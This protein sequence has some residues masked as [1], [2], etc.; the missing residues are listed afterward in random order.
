MLNELGTAKALLTKIAGSYS[1]AASE[2]LKVLLSD[3]SAIRV[4]IS[5]EI[6]SALG[7]TLQMTP[8]QFQQLLKSPNSVART[9][10]NAQAAAKVAAVINEQLYVEQSL[11]MQRLEEIRELIRRIE[12][13]ETEP[14]SNLDVVARD[15]AA[16]K[17]LLEDAK[18]TWSELAKKYDT[19][20]VNITEL[21]KQL[22]ITHAQLDLVLTQIT[23]HVKV[24]Q[25]EML[26]VLKQLPPVEGLT[27]V[28]M[29]S[30]AD[31]YAERMQMTDPTSSAKAHAMYQQSLIALA[32][33]ADVDSPIDAPEKTNQKQE[34]QQLQQTQQALTKLSVMDA[35][36]M[37][38]QDIAPA[39]RNTKGMQLEPTAKE[40][41]QAVKVINTMQKTE[42]PAPKLGEP[43][44]MQNV[45]ERQRE[46]LTPQF[47]QLDH[48]S[49]QFGR[50]SQAMQSERGKILDMQNASSVLT[51]A[52]KP[53]AMTP[54]MSMGPS[55]K[56]DPEED[57]TKTP[58]YKSPTPFNMRLTPLKGKLP[59]AR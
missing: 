34:Q 3:L 16:E 21:Q 50:L 39:L 13:R 2:S 4:K 58:D 12:A 23:K 8:A 41:L 57:Q 31:N 20:V 30:I 15:L 59:P 44:T 6:M 45:F 32:K 27:A 46:M 28:H 17:K 18:K 29:A 5:P 24:Y 42:V 49:R 22:D 37:I 51:N 1:N 35:I 36:K 40:L 9:Q 11:I 54:S 19:S 14:Y 7:P 53:L 25:T 10:I 52:L 56:A 26:S 48:L 33:Q 55:K 47:L 43:K 38:S